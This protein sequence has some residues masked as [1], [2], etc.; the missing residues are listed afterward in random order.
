MSIRQE[1]IQELSRGVAAGLDDLIIKG[2]PEAFHIKDVSYAEYPNKVRVFSYRGE[3]FLELHPMVVSYEGLAIKA[4]H[5]YRYL[6]P[7][8]G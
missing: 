5:L 8:V 2:L 7:G 4:T 1:A 3:P 6:K